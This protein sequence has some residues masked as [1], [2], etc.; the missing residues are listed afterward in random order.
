MTMTKAEIITSIKETLAKRPHY[1]VVVK[2]Y[3]KLNFYRNRWHAYCI[4]S[5]YGTL[6]AS[7]WADS[8]YMWQPDLMKLTKPELESLLQKVLSEIS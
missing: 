8:D 2:E 6:Y 5:R 1:P 7:P 3:Q 4:Y